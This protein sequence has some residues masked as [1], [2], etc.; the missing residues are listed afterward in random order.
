MCIRDRVSTQSTWDNISVIDTASFML[1]ETQMKNL[2]KD[3]SLKTELVDE[4]WEESKRTPYELL[5]NP[6]VSSSLVFYSHRPSSG[7]LFWKTN[8]RSKTFHGETY[9]PDAKRYTQGDGVV[10]RTS[11][12]VAGLKWAYEFDSKKSSTAKPVKIVDVCSVYNTQK[13]VW[14]RESETTGEKFMASNDYVGS[15]CDCL[16]EDED[17]HID[18]KNCKHTTILGDS[19]V[20]DY[21]LQLLDS[22]DRPRGVEDTL[23]FYLTEEELEDVFTECYALRLDTGCLLYTSPSPRDQA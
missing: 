16:N 7:T 6:E 11:A 19:G 3:F 9:Y 10:T 8:P 15:K 5:P 20:I 2:V 23:A 12:L 14:D 13:P 17:K 4:F 22:G 21:V 18:G 1:E